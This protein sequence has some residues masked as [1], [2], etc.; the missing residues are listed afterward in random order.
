MST[1][2]TEIINRQ[3]L[4]AFI[5]QHSIKHAWL[6]SKLNVSEKTLSR[7]VNGSVTRIRVANLRKL[8]NVL[9]CDINTLIA[10]SEV[11]VYSSESNRDIL[12]NELFNDSLLYEL[13]VGSKVRLAISLIKSTF[14]SKLPSAII[15][16]F[17]TKL[18]Y[19]A[20]IQRKQK[21][22]RGY[23]DKA[24]NKARASDNREVIFSVN[25]AFA[26][27]HFL[28]CDYAKCEQRLADCRDWFDYAGQEEAH[29]FNTYALLHLYTGKFELAIESATRCID[30]CSPESPS[31]EKALFISTALQLKGAANM[32]LGEGEQ[33]RRDCER[34]LLV[35][36]RSGYA[37]CSW[38]AKA[39]L[40]C[41]YAHT[42]ELD[43]ALTLIEESA[44]QADP[45]DLSYA[46]V[47][48]ASALVYRHSGDYERVNSLVEQIRHTCPANSAP[49]AFAYYQLAML[50]PPADSNLDAEQALKKAR[51]LTTQL[52]LHHW[53]A[54]LGTIASVN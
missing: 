13:I 29:Y 51:T 26:I 35:A 16:S 5:N 1:S 46:T 19:A 12:V 17:Y 15:A 24:L 48:C 28:D 36:E 22:A 4:A 43:L 18:G 14:H 34:S 21:T 7:W 31:I 49:V 23:L 52:Q 45:E 40:A 8:A 32:L 47:L 44:E 54:F 30:S 27:L 33:A 42:D 25:L 6:A 2:K 9:E 39:Y 37:R 3:R 53:T 10:T 11:D 41:V 38:M 50:T 20:I